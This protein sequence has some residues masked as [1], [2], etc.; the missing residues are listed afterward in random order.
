MTKKLLTALLLMISFLSLAQEEGETPEVPQGPKINEFLFKISHPNA[1][2]TAFSIKHKGGILLISAGHVCKDITVPDSKQPDILVS[3][4]TPGGMKT[5][6]YITAK[7]IFVSSASDICVLK[8]KN[9]TEGLETSE[10][11][12]AD[13][14]GL[15]TLGLSSN[16]RP[17]VA[18]L[19]PKMPDRGLGITVDVFVPAFFGDS[20]GPIINAEQKVVAIIITVEG[21]NIRNDADVSIGRNITNGVP[22]SVLNAYIKELGL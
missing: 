16:R 3:H 22:V 11:E 2:G 14:E 19:G 10:G 15:I 5:K 1:S 7:N 20:G 18:L 21:Y 17:S 12:I 6:E 13:K 8:T 4:I 9:I